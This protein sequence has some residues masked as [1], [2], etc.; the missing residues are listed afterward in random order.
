[1]VIFHGYA[2]NAPPRPKDPKGHPGPVTWWDLGLTR[3][4][5]S[6]AHS[7][8]EGLRHR[9]FIP[10]TSS[11]WRGKNDK[12]CRT[13]LHLRITHTHTKKKRSKT[14]VSN[15][16]PLNQCIWHHHFPSGRSETMTFFLP[17]IRLSNPSTSD[18]QESRKLTFIAW[19]SSLSL[20][21]CW[22][23]MGSSLNSRVS[24][25]GADGI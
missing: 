7:D 14:M 1:M 18:L 19:S 22:S 21:V 20:R 9:P 25:T 17:G 23:R 13:P 4:W 12:I 15:R 8:L 11:G 6:A 3:S 10:L 16:F 2:V 24:K 5:G